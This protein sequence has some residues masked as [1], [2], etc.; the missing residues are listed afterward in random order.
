MFYSNLKSLVSKSVVHVVKRIL[1]LQDRKM[2]VLMV[3]IFSILHAQE[4]TVHIL[5]KQLQTKIIQCTQHAH[6]L[7]TRA[8]TYA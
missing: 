8:H 4:R 5:T 6:T 7:Y 1:I 2:H 3:C